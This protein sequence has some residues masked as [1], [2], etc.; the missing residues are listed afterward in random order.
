MTGSALKQP[1]LF[2][3]RD[4]VL[5]ENRDQYVLQWQDVAFLPSTLHALQTAARSDYLIVIVTNQSAVGRGLL[6][7]EG[8]Q[9]INRRIVEVIETHGG[10]IDAA[11]FCPHAPDDHCTCRKPQP[12]MLLQA[13]GD[14]NIDLSRSVMVG[15]AL[16]DIMAGQAAGVP[17]TILVRTGRGR[18]QAKLPL[19]TSLRPFSVADDLSSALTELSA[20]L[21]VR[22]S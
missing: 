3:D 5:I 12:G 19:A 11:Y 9:A 8:A 7:L 22:S 2:L 21:S 17:H 10:R 6:S 15:D 13:A 4:G 16:S 20:N 1:A 18:Q 14:L